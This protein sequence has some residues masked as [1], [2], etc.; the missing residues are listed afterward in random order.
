M[1]MSNIMNGKIFKRTT[2]LKKKTPQWQNELEDDH[3]IKGTKSLSNI[4]QRC[5]VAIQKPA[6]H[7]KTSQIPQM[8]ESNGGGDV[9]D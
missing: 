9:N 3:L 2:F 1:K 8:E 4:Y 7:K 5:K 6:R